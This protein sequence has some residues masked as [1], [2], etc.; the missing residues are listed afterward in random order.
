[1]YFDPLVIITILS[2]E[3][4]R[5]LVEQSH[6]AKILLEDLND[7]HV[8]HLPKLSDFL[9]VLGAPSIDQFLEEADTV[10]RWRIASVQRLVAANRKVSSLDA[11]GKQ[12]ES[13]DEDDKWIELYAKGHVPESEQIL[14]DRISKTTDRTELAHYYND[15]GY[16]RYS[17]KKV[18]AEKDLETAL[19]LHFHHLTLTLLNL[20]I[21]DIDKGNYPAAIQKIEDALFLTLNRS[22]IE[23]GYLRL[24]LPRSQMDQIER[25]E[26]RPAN[27]LEA[28]YI[29]LA[30]ALL[31]MR[32]PGEAI[33]TL[34]EGL[35]LLHNSA[36]LKHALAR[37]HLCEKHWALADS[38]YLETSELMIDDQIIKNEVEAYV[39]RLSRSG[40]DR[41][42]SRG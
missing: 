4:R 17:L 27:C 39:K 30:Y 21:V 20:S 41:K 6:E 34:Q 18:E 36:R 9:R 33:E 23:A 13:Q 29:N 28:S 11:N 37:L 2:P 10:E 25:C 22:N 3:T 19:S 12:E 7:I 15:R 31:K 42:Q 40:R 35:A 38:M 1:M 5:I 14:N 16:I 8:P 32:K 26:Q 24:R